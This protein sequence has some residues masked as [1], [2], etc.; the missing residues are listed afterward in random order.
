M[1]KETLMKN[2]IDVILI[3]YIF[4]SLT[5]Y[6]YIT[7]QSAEEL[8]NIQ[9]FIEEYYFWGGGQTYLAV[10]HSKLLN[11][12]LSIITFLI[13]ILLFKFRKIRKHPRNFNKATHYIFTLLFVPIVFY[14]LWIKEWELF[15]SYDGSYIREITT[16][17]LIISSFQAGFISEFWY[18]ID[19][20]EKLYKKIMN[21][22]NE[23]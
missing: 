7:N 19:I 15:S 1:K 4:I 16:Y 17:I 23:Q 21:K 5:L 6:F 20:L 18:F 2:I 12:I 11:F 3:F 22:Q 9:K 14:F 10:E 8:F 13:I